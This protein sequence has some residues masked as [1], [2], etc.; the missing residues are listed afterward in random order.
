LQ[1]DRLRTT[2]STRAGY[3]GAVLNDVVFQPFSLS[4]GFRGAPPAV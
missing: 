1:L 4:G 2:A 3:S